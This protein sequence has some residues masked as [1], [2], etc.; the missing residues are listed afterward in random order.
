VNYNK[1]LRKKSAVY[2]ATVW[3]QSS[4]NT[5]INTRVYVRLY[6]EMLIQLLK[7]MPWCQVGSVEWINYAHNNQYCCFIYLD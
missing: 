4:G 6:L 1:E 7:I 3:H 2:M 5:V